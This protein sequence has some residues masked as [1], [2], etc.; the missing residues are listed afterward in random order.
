MKLLSFYILTW[1]NFNCRATHLLTLRGHDDMGIWNSPDVIKNDFY[2]KNGSLNLFMNWKSV[3][4]TFWAQEDFI[5]V[6]KNS[7]RWVAPQINLFE[8]FAVVIIL[9]CEK[10]GFPMDPRSVVIFRSC[11][12][13]HEIQKNKKISKSTFFSLKKFK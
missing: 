9:F 4:T 5:E 1:K 8:S 7:L 6:W 11:S 2:K 13:H 10:M 3:L 12:G